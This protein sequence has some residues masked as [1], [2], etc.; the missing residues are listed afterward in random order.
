[1][2]LIGAEVLKLVRRRGLMA[3]SLLLTC[4]S[5]VIAE[6]VLLILHAV[7]PAHHGPAGGARNLEHYM[8]LVTGLGDVAAILIAATVGTQDATNGVFRDLVVTGRKRS[9]L[10][11]VRAPGALLVFLPMLAIS[12]ALAVGGSFAFAGDLATPSA[13]TIARW[14]EYALA[15]TVVNM[16][17]AIGLSAFASSRVVVGVMIAWNAIVAQLLISIT[18]LG[19]VRK[20]IDVAAA[21][22]FSP[23]ARGSSNVGMASI[24]AL[25]VLAGW[26]VVFSRAGRWWTVRQDA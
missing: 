17:I 12:F 14:A 20:F 24:T 3:W 22:H 18:S 5:V 23:S 21:Q 9:A 26:A 8:F 4:G 11:N 16:I 13:H 6:I 19:G 10:F 2:R 25:L 15:I 7:N 1:M